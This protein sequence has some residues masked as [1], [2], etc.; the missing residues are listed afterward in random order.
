M[1]TVEVY[2]H[3]NEP[4]PPELK[5][6][7]ALLQLEQQIT[8]RYWWSM[9]FIVSC[10]D[11]VPEWSR[12]LEETLNRRPGHYSF[13]YQLYTS[14]VCREQ[15]RA[16]LL[17]F[18]SLVSRVEIPLKM[19]GLLEADDEC[20]VDLFLET[21]DCTFVPLSLYEEALRGRLV[22]VTVDLLSRTYSSAALTCMPLRC[23][24][25]WFEVV[26]I[27]NTVQRVLPETLASFIVRR[28]SL[29][30]AFALVAF[31]DVCWD[32]VRNFV[33]DRINRVIQYN[34]PDYRK[35]NV[36]SNA[37]RALNYKGVLQ[38]VFESVS[39]EAQKLIARA[40]AWTGLVVTDLLLQEKIKRYSLETERR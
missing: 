23:G 10:L 5:D 22:P 14:E 31:R 11:V 13:R 15:V 9:T 29:S 3:N 20:L 28:R 21:L 35:F 36:F 33:I 1:P 38:E 26:M 25:D 7:E 34:W 2:L 30:E 27:L 4:C 18:P 39:I 17:K 16:H 37:V 6:R 19:A 12:L 40:A 32:E 8:S 24:R